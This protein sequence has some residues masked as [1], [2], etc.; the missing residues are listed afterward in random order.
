MLHVKNLQLVMVL[1]FFSAHFQAPKYI[2]KGETGQ[3]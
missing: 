3:L 1:S 2:D